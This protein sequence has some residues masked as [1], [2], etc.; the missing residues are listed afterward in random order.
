[1]CGY[2]DVR[3]ACL[4]LLSAR[5]VPGKFDAKGF[6]S[7]ADL[8]V[9]LCHSSLVVAVDSLVLEDFVSAGVHCGVLVHVYW[10]VAWLARLAHHDFVG[11]GIFDHDRLWWLA[12]SLAMLLDC[13]MLGLWLDPQFLSV[14]LPNMFSV[15]CACC[16]ACDEMLSFQRHSGSDISMSWVLLH[17]GMESS[18]LHIDNFDVGFSG[19]YPVCFVCGPGMNKSVKDVCQRMGVFAFSVSPSQVGIV[20]A[21]AA[22]YGFYFMFS[23]V[24]QVARRAAAAWRAGAFVY[25]F[26]VEGV[27]VLVCVFLEWFLAACASEDVL[28]FVDSGVYDCEFHKEDR[29]NTAG[30]L[31][32]GTGD[33]ASGRVPGSVPL[34]VPDES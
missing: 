19:I 25:I 29:P 20:A 14:V 33:W 10:S 1:M 23:I 27:F 30:C 28:S 21:S 24:C 9:C 17:T 3:F 31:S 34:D 2:I 18:L 5:A 12:R 32:V 4:V 7:A 6:G 22:A 15:S 11:C 26:C 8:G 16:D 13:A